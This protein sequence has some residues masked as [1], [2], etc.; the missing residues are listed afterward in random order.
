MV[1]ATPKRNAEEADLPELQ[2]DLRAMAELADEIDSVFP[3]EWVI[4]PETE[5][6]QQ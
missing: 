4:E 6:N 3:A 2:K 5:N 1:N